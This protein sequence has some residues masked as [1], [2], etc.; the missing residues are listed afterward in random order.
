MSSQQQLASVTASTNLF[1]TRNP[2]A[3]TPFLNKTIDLSFGSGLQTYAAGETKNVGPA[4]QNGQAGDD[5]FSIGAA[6]SAAGG[7]A[8]SLS[9]ES[10][11]DTGIQ[12][13]P[14]FISTGLSTQA[15]CGAR[16]PLPLP[17][18]YAYAHTAGTQPPPPRAC[19]SRVR[20]CW[21]A[22][23]CQAQS[24]LRFAAFRSDPALAANQ[25]SFSAHR[26]AAKRVSTP[27][28]ASTAATW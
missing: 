27:S 12:G 11:T 17:H 25:L 9:C 23:L 13:G 2:N 8:L 1:C 20:C 7:G 16:I 28:S 14:G 26:T 24:P 18:P 6:L 10:L 22:W 15:G 21:S 19:P 5:V 3:L 4:S